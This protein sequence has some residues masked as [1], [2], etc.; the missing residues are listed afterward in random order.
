LSYI[1]RPLNSQTTIFP[2]Y[3]FPDHESATWA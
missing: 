2:D 3:D 1:P